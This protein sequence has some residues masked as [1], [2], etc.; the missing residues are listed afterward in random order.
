[1]GFRFITAIGLLCLAAASFGQKISYPVFETDKIPI[2]QLKARRDAVKAKLGPGGV[3]IFFTNPV[4]N[5]NNDCDFRF[6][7][8]SN[9]LYLTGFE[10]PDSAL[11][12][13]PDGFVFDGQ[14]VTELL[15]VNESDPFSIT[16]LG[17]RM[18]SQDAK[19]LLGM[20]AVTSNSRFADGLK[21]LEAIPK[22]HIWGFSVP[23][24]PSGKVEQMITSATQWQSKLKLPVEPQ[25]GL[26]TMLAKLRVKKTPEE[27]E[28]LRHAAQASA[29]GHREVMRSV[30]PGM[31]EYEVQALV[32]YLFAR[33]GCEF[34]GYS[35]IV[36]SGPNS[37]ILHYEDNRRL[38]QN[39]DMIC[40][41]AAGEYH[42]YSADV[43]RSFPSNG[44]F[45]PAQKAIYELVLAAQTAGIAQCKAGTRFGAAGSAAE[46]VITDGLIKLGIM[47]SARDLRTYLPH[48][49]SHYIGLDVHDSFG[50]G[51]LHPGYVL[52]VEPGIYIRAGSAC[53]PKWWNIGVR[54]ED[55]VLVTEHAPEVLSAGAPRTINEIEALMKQT[56]IGK[57]SA[58]L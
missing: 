47:K 44:K 24:D 23:P 27:L 57:R 4:R 16:W 7:G 37:C 49:V 6:R 12:L 22:L 36:G 3:G 34:P 38:I 26:S 33:N 40:M 21:A 29:M 9:F 25:G 14:K 11:I 31:R 54:I 10:E 18:G 20:E 46:K 35:S 45:S 32:E 17:Y 19:S 5:R 30:H 41:D 13:A 53:D 1:M 43:T 51:T 8:D 56:G 50:D 55:D 28:L 52:T 42:G 48:G 39:G 15:V 58:G 2:G